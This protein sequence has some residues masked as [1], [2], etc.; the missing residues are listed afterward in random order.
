MNRKMILVI[1]VLAI[2]IGVGWYV[3]PQSRA[4]WGPFELLR[5]ED[6]RKELKLSHDQFAKIKPLVENISKVYQELGPDKE[7]ALKKKKVTRDTFE[8]LSKLLTPE[9]LHRMDQLQRQQ[10]GPATFYDPRT[11][12]LLELTGEQKDQIKK[13]LDKSSL[14]R[15]ELHQKSAFKKLAKLDKEILSEIMNVLD[16]EQ[17]RGFNKMLGEPFKGKLPPP[18]YFP[19]PKK[20]REE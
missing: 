14:Q 1:A 9:Q 17:K 19:A 3:W 15:F 7:N 2:G 10:L 8:A 20:V 4:K 16:E 11:A 18:N 13:I 12:R 5:Y 6:V